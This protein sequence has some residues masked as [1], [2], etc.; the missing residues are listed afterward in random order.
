M[1]NASK[2]GIWII[3][4]EGKTVFANLRMAEI[5]G[6][7]PSEMIGQ[8]SFEYVYPEDLPAATRLFDAKAQGDARAFR[9]K[10]RCADGSAVWVDALGTPL[11][12]PAGV[13][14]GIVG[15]FA[16]ISTL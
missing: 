16:T 14:T 10:L 2:D 12:N 1:P 4:V 5:L 9:F 13:F 11:Y 8:N 3:D 15:T 7:S 6:T